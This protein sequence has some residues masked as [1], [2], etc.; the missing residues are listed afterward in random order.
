MWSLHSIETG[1]RDVTG[2]TKS[3]QQSV[4]RLCLGFY[5]NGE[6]ASEDKVVERAFLSI[7]TCFVELFVVQG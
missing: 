6:G 5:L 3:T 7:K 4:D 2:V 1:L